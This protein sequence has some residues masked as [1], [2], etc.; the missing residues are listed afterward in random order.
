MAM[1]LNKGKYA[2]MVKDIASK[3]REENGK[4]TTRNI[5][6][7]QIDKSADNEK[8]FSMDNRS[9]L[10][11]AIDRN[12]FQGTVQVYLNKEGRYTLLSGHR[13]FES[14][15]DLGFK[16]I[17]CEIIAE[18]SEVQK[19]EILIMSN[20]TAR[21]LTP[22]EK[23]RAIKY[24]EKNVLDKENFKGDKRAEL[25]RRFGMTSS[26]VY[27]I[28]ATADLIRPLQ[29]LIERGDVPYSAIYTASVMSEETQMAIHSKLIEEIDQNGSC[30]GRTA[31]L[32][33]QSF[34]P[35]SVTEETKTA[36]KEKEEVEKIKE[37]SSSPQIP[38]TAP[39]F[40][41]DDEDDEEELFKSPA[42]MPVFSQRK[43]FFE[44][45][46]ASP[47]ISGKKISFDESRINSE[48]RNLC[49]LLTK[50]KEIKD[51]DT[52]EKLTSL[53]NILNEFLK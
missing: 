27:K 29:D 16:E 10:T 18:P 20:V 28:K 23:G 4:K 1:D 15:K 24:Y 5:P 7:D 38:E 37:E 32:I 22:V 34:T 9:R 35:K 11:D 26:Q 17:P 49:E 8:I 2:N 36:Q 19:A 13:R 12:G 50:V 39:Q 53:K 51:E 31:E 45:D 47:R 21:D 44:N 43:P 42:N 30:S 25:G 41:D 52:I 6:I 3:S 48:A 33:V 46:F 40:T 14:A